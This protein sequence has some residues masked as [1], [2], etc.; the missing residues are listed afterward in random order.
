MLTEASQGRTELIFEDD[1]GFRTRKEPSSFW[2]VVTPWAKARAG[3]SLVRAEKHP[4]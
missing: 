3:K 4:V 2:V 1:K